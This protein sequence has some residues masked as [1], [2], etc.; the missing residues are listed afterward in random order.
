MMV[1]FGVFMIL[2]LGML[3]YGEF[4]YRSAISRCSD[5][6]VEC[7]EKREINKDDC[8]M[9]YVDCVYPHYMEIIDGR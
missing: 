5:E 9:K 1:P 8:V 2:F 7:V 3:L 6:Y 4:D